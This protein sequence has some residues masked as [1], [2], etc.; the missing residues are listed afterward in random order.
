M[1][2]LYINEEER[3]RFIEK[4]GEQ[5][6]RKING[7]RNCVFRSEDG[8]L[9]MVFH[10]QD[11]AKVII[12]AD[13]EECAVATDDHDMIETAKGTDPDLRG[14]RAMFDFLI[15]MSEDDIDKLEQLEDKVVAMEDR[16]FTDSISDSEAVKDIL[17]FRKEIL[18]RK[19][20]YEKMEHLTD[21]LA[22]LDDTF[23][24]LDRRFDRLLNFVLRMQEYVEQVREAYQSQIDI[25]QNNLMKYFTVVSTIVLPLTLIT[26]WYGMNVKMPEFGWKYGYLFVICLSIAIFGLMIYIFKKKKWL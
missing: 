22:G 5:S 26:G 13:E 20:Y 9:Y 23:V 11:G 25:E 17:R 10:T 21:E 19:R 12:R 16:I 24:F 4:T 8:T 6:A 3:K 7:S 18:R 1:I 2:E 15:D 14:V